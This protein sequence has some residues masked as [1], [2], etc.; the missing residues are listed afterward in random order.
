MEVASIV[1]TIVIGSIP[2]FFKIKNDK[3]KLNWVGYLFLFLVTC[4]I[5]MNIYVFKDDEEKQTIRDSLQKEIGIK[6]A[7]TE[8]VIKDL[9]KKIQDVDSINKKLDS[10]SLKTLELLD[11]RIIQNSKFDSLSNYL[12]KINNNLE[13]DIYKDL[14]NLLIFDT[15]KWVKYESIY[16]IQ[17][18]L[19][20]DGRR[21]QNIQMGIYYFV[22]NNDMLIEIRDLL[23][24]FKGGFEGGKENMIELK[25]PIHE[26]IKEMKDLP[27]GYLV[28]FFKYNDP[29]ISDSIQR[30]VNYFSWSYISEESKYLERA[31]LSSIESIKE[32]ISRNKIILKYTDGEIFNNF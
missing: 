24:D 15:P 30:K 19:E 9:E 13:V 21:A 2:I 11:K 26:H 12:N 7:S 4:S 27:K 3:N 10:V 6:T 17:I 29:I 1:F 32:V 28:I 8:E 5:I 23:L 20:Q 22:L 18:I 25:V 31:S 14:S 16:K